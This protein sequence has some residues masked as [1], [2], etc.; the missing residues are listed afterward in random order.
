MPDDARVDELLKEL[1][2]SGATPEEVC[3]ACPELLEPVRAGWQKVRALQAEIGELFPEAPSTDLVDQ[4]QIRPPERST[5]DLP[6]IRGYEVLEVLGQGG[7]G[8]V[9]KAWHVRLRRSVAVK[10]LLAGAYAKPLELERFMREA[11]TI[12]G[13]RHPNIVQVH[14]AGDVDG[15][16]Y[17][18]MELVEGGNL[19]DKVAGIPQPAREA[20]ALVATVAEAVHLAHQRGIV[21]RDLKPGNILLTADGTPK[22]TDFGVARHLEGAAS[23]T[24]TG[25]PIGTPSYMAPEQAEGKSRNVGPAADTYALGVILY[26]LLTARPPFRAETAAETLRQV[27]SQDPVP[28]A[29]LNAKVPRDLDIIC[30]KCLQ[31]DAGKRYATA[32]DLAAD[33]G[34]FLRHEPIR[35]RP[36]GGAEYVLRWVRRRPAVAGLLAAVLLLLLVGGVGGALLYHQWAAARDRQAQTARQ[37]RW[38]LQQARNPLKEAWQTQDLAKLTEA[39]AEGNRAVDIA[40]SGEASAAVRQE[41]EAFRADAGQRLGRAKKNRALLQ[42]VLDVSD[43]QESGP[44]AQDKTGR[45]IVLNQPSVDEQYAAA[46]RR[47]GLDMDGTAEAE[48]AERLRAEP[49]GVVQELIAALD[50][51]MMERRRQGRPDV[52]WR[53]LYRFADQLDPSDRRHRLRALSVDGLPPRAE[54]VAGLVGMGSPWSALWEQARGNTWRHLREVHKEIDPRKEPALTVVLLA[55]AC[56]AVGDTAAAEKVLRRA[57]TVQPGQVVL[58]DAMGKLLER[59]G[60]SR[61]EEAIGYY[62]GARGQRHYLGI[63]LSKALI[64]A[65]RAAEAEELMKELILLQPDNAAFHLQFG[66]A[67]YH[68]KKVAEA[69][70]HFRKA[71]DVNPAFASAYSNLGAILSEQQKHREAE[72]VLRKA[73]NL[74]PDFVEAYVN[75]G[76]ALTR[77]ERYGEAEAAYRKAIDLKPDFA[78][79]HCNLS[80]ALMGQK[81]HA[82]AEA[83]CRKAIDLKPDLAVAYINLGGALMEKGKYGEAAT[84]FQKA[85]DL[86]PSSDTGYYNLGGVRMIQGRLGEAE[87]AYRKAIDLKPDHALAYTNLGGSLALQGKYGEAEVAIRKSLDLDPGL[88]EAYYNL[89]VALMQQAKLDE[90]AQALNKADNLLP[91]TNPT[92]AKARRHLKECQ[93]YLSLDA[94]LP[95]ILQGVQKPADA[96]EQVELAQL[97]RLKKHYA[98][99]ARFYAAAF[100][101][102]PQLAEDVPHGARYDAACAAA[103]AA[104]AS[105][106]EAETPDSKDLAR[107][108]R[109]ALDWLR[110]DIAWWA[111]KLENG[112]AQVRLS[113][114]HRL[115]Q[116]QSDPDLAGVRDKAEL[117]LLPNEEREQWERLWSDLDALLRRVSGHE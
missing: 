12:A 19:F 84:A 1:L 41:A 39:L 94:R 116:S 8:V 75:L 21:H 69:Q 33:L 9:Y 96:A 66:V 2:D 13:L 82:E 59:L 60:P 62:R 88:D 46:F 68:R 101:A 51:W 38:I 40:Q 78:N 89:G 97:C 104:C 83:A 45:P 37:A 103:L 107:L 29:R 22:L 99:A 113:A 77:Q 61:L 73:I 35:A 17:F 24:Q 3:R 23:L 106:K 11:E 80:S 34:R 6:S 42:A 27:V 95:A 30:L 18:T 10:M 81:R 65:G 28:P 87:A 58:L 36:T 48:V 108:R 7:M 110:E 49:E 67:A 14:E 98:A 54:W 76:N 56:A 114:R 102:E 5:H 55:Q 47:W 92:R 32:A 100:T 16:P 15:R 20:A 117:G 70:T 93:R 50:G 53:R 25:V 71:I 90:A 44:Y 85:I 4:K 105:G 31:K 115:Q 64:S 111:K 91:A 74:K 57:T 86:D 112:T 43:P 52:E 26:E 109:Q 63:S 79:A 72:E